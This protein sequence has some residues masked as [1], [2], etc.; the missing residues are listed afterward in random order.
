MYNFRRDYGIAMLEEKK[1]VFW[2]LQMKW[3]EEYEGNSFGSTCRK[4]R[5]ELK[6]NPHGYVNENHIRVHGR[7]TSATRLHENDD[8][9][10]ETDRDDEED[11]GD[12]GMPDIGSG[13]L[14][15]QKG[16]ATSTSAPFG[17][18]PMKLNKNTKL[19]PHTLAPEDRVFSN[20]GHLQLPYYAVLHLDQPD[21]TGDQR[22]L[23]LHVCIH[24]LSGTTDGGFE[25][26]I[27]PKDRSQMIFQDQMGESGKI[28]FGQES[29]SGLRK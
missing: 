28:F 29:T 10:E 4:I 15:P 16:P 5:D 21:Q 19:N 9:E 22:K 17:A 7:G 24:C 12:D 1:P 2:K 26:D 20:Q 13:P 25:V 8:T 23:S 27:N 14:K 3:G 18:A 6:L 11:A